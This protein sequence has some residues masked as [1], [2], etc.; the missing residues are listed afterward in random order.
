M[1]CKLFNKP[2][3]KNNV[4]SRTAYSDATLKYTSMV[5]S[6]LPW[7]EWHRTL[8]K[9]QEFLLFGHE[10]KKKNVMEPSIKLFLS[11]YPVPDGYVMQQEK[12]MMMEVT[13]P[14]FNREATPFPWQNDEI[15]V[16]ESEIDRELKESWDTFHQNPSPTLQSTDQEYLR[17]RIEIFLKDATEKLKLM[18]EYLVETFRAPQA[19]SLRLALLYLS[20]RIPRVTRADYFKIAF[21]DEALEQLTFFLDET[22]RLIL[23]NAVLLYLQLE[24]FVARLDRIRILLSSDRVPL[25][26]VVQEWT[27]VRQW[28]PRKHPEWLVFEA[29]GLIQIRPEQFKVANHIIHNPGAITQLNM[30]CGKTRV[31]LP[32][33]VLYFCLKK[34]RSNLKSL[35]RIVRLHFLTALLR[36]AAGYLHL[37][38]TAS[39]FNLPFLEVPF[40]REVDINCLDIQQLDHVLQMIQRYGG[41][42]LC[43]PE[44]RLS[45]SLKLKEFIYEKNST[46]RTELLQ[47]FEKWKFLDIL[48][49]SDALL[50]HKYHLMYA[51]GNAGT[52]EDCLYRAYAVQGLL[53][54]LN[55][56]DEVCYY[57]NQRGVSVSEHIEE[58]G[59]YRKIRL[60][61]KMSETT[62]IRQELVTTLLESFIEQPPYSFRWI[63]D[64]VN[65]GKISKETFV[66][67]IT[68]Y[69]ESINI[70]IGCEELG[71][72]YRW[73]HL[74]IL[75]GLLGSGLLEYA[76]ELRANVNYGIDTRRKKR[77]AVPYQAADMPSER[78][79][80]GHPDLSLILTMLAYYHI[81][82]TKEQMFESLQY[83]LS[84]S[85]DSQRYHYQLWFEPISNDLFANG[86]REKMDD[87]VKI[88]LNNVTQQE[89]LYSKYRYSTEA[90]NFWLNNC[91]FPVDLGQFPEN[92]SASAWHLAEGDWQIGFSGTNDTHLLYPARVVQNDPDCAHLRGT[93]GKM[94]HYLIE[95]TLEY[96]A[97]ANYDL[98]IWQSALWESLQFKNIAAVIDTGS[99]LAGVSNAQVAMFL[100]EQENFPSDLLGVLYFELKEQ[101]GGQ[102]MMLDKKT[103]LAVT[104]QETHILERDAFIV[105]DEARSRGT[106]MKMRPHAVASLIIG[107]NLTKDRLMQGAGRLRQL[108]KGQRIVMLAPPDVDQLIKQQLN[109][110]TVSAST[111]MHWVSINT[112]SFIAS[113]LTE[114][115]MS[116]LAFAKSSLNTVNVAAERSKLEELYL[117]GQSSFLLSEKVQQEIEKTLKE[118]EPT[119]NMDVLEVVKSR[120]QTYGNTIEIKSTGFNYEVERELALEREKEMEQE[121]EIEYPPLIP[122]TETPWQYAEVMKCKSVPDISKLTTVL[123]MDQVFEESISLEGLEKIEWDYG[124]LYCTE[125][126][127]ETIKTCER[128]KLD[129]FVRPAD[130]FIKLPDDDIVL[131]SD[132]EMDGILGVALKKNGPIQV[133]SHVPLRSWIDTQEKG[134]FRNSFIIMI[135]DISIVYLLCFYSLILQ[136]YEKI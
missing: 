68:N 112:Q 25:A 16:L 72:N 28:D 10:I 113:G 39:T 105:F 30:G 11:P 136:I 20:N 65:A 128:V 110:S 14:A 43:A 78:S 101:N 127:L 90:I 80:F 63:S 92:I 35:H 119:E 96:R 34:N 73:Q 85:I 49:E 109:V 40:S 103:G 37:R 3:T 88:D 61:Q 47:F 102:W 45:L 100:I 31:I 12:A 125:A 76:L 48:D 120:C 66:S 130:G 27:T 55:N 15:S 41:C 95:H 93:N 62:A 58:G 50:S 38:L 21:D 22:G 2:V 33:L 135:I 98:K 64:F 117:E 24:I 91:V 71:E 129:Y 42:I 1:F 59:R 83:M 26:S 32:M 36:E 82:L 115:A 122:I 81:G 123:S 121:N 53:A 52:L 44:H 104:R 46:L 23:R 69:N 106:D 94:L 8:T 79:E 75:R 111:V 13:I 18:D 54:V 19:T 107:P 87:V 5:N 4:V 126:F 67:A 70:F 57:L 60:V 97:T 132:Q 56:S 89:L 118:Q 108:S 114:W 116:G 7:N 131:L 74:L 51:M 9:R 84:L 124:R 99:V 134:P 86:E 29:E 17:Q 6:D 77:L 133:G